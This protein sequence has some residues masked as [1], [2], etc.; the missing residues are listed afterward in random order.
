MLL[1]ASGLL[2]NKMERKK[3]T[4][5]PEKSIFFHI[6]FAGFRARHAATGRYPH[7]CVRVSCV[8]TVCSMENEKK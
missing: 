7:L 3:T 8:V 5:F 1:S 6:F 4:H 2:T